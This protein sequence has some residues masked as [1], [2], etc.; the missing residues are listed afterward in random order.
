MALRVYSKTAAHAARTDNHT[1]RNYIV[2]SDTSRVQYV[3]NRTNMWNVFAAAYGTLQK[4]VASSSTGGMLLPLLLIMGGLGFIYMQ[5]QPSLKE[6]VRTALNLTNQGNVA[7]VSSDYIENRLQYV[8]NPGA[9]YFRKLTEAAIQNGQ[10]ITDTESMAFNGTFYVSIPKL[11]INRMPVQSNVDSTNS[12][13]Y[14]RVLDTQLAHFKGSSLPFV[15]NPGNIV[16]YGHSVGGSYVPRPND[17]VSAFTFLPELKVG[18]EILIEI[19]GQTHK[20]VMRRSRVVMPDDTSILAS[21]PGQEAL[22][23]FTCYPP[24]SR[25]KRLVISAVPVQV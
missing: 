20:Y 6:E 18:D 16:I 7:L 11:G 25:D 22:T 24:G 5:V 14:N 12:N 19:A 17:V 8:S 21:T 23:L 3:Q 10:F 4:L 1:P 2:L 13:I 9:D 15:A